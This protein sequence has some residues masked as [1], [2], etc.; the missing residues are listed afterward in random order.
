MTYAYALCR[1]ITPSV[2]ISNE[3]DTVKNG[4]RV[5][6]VVLKSKVVK[7]RLGEVVCAHLRRR[8]S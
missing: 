4:G 8:M 1:K 5:K 6:D 7:I 3:N 2:C